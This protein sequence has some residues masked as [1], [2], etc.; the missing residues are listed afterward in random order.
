MFIIKI[1]FLKR[2]FFNT[3]VINCILRGETGWGRDAQNDREVPIETE[4][5]AHH[6]LYYI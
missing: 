3:S 6:E 2:L 5:V 4:I 1:K